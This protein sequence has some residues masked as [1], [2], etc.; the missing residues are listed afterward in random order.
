[1]SS[2][3]IKRPSTVLT[4]LAA[5]TL[6]LGILLAAF[7]NVVIDDLSNDA[8]LINEAG[9]VR[10]S[11]QRLSKLVTYDS[12]VNIHDQVVKIDTL[13]SKMFTVSKVE[14]PNTAELAFSDSV[15]FLQL[16]WKELKKL[17]QQ[18]V[19]DVDIHNHKQIIEASEAW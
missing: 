2:L 19:H 13:I 8:S 1:M 12:T 14:N 5:I 9:I 17:I 18:T 15:S 3:K 11:I 4:I 6:S 10:G 7:F 16:Q